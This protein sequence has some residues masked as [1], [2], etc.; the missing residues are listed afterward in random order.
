MA[1]EKRIDFGMFGVMALMVIVM[2]AFIAMSIYAALSTRATRERL[3][4][5]VYAEET[6]HYTEITGINEAGAKY[7]TRSGYRNLSQEDVGLA[8]SAIESAGLFGEHP[9][10]PLRRTD[11]LAIEG[12][13]RGRFLGGS[14][15]E[16]SG[17]TQQHLVFAWTSGPREFIS[18]LP[19]RQIVIETLPEGTAPAI[20]FKFDSQALLRQYVAS[21][22]SSL[23]NLNSFITDDIVIHAT[24]FISE[25]DKE[26][27]IYFLV[28]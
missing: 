10:M 14:D 11:V 15:G 2:G 3:Q 8:M 24:V 12:E 5:T 23:Y 6:A 20:R 7:A 9:L 1:R 27:G 19:L 16:I 26:N 18:Y 17:T 25:E 28:R 22:A 13:L 4:N 21:P